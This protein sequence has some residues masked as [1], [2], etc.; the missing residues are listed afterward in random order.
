MDGPRQGI[1]S[2]IV[3]GSALQTM[4]GINKEGQLHEQT[5]QVITPEN[6]SVSVLF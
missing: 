5:K 3:F 6:T 1:L 4:G 2:K